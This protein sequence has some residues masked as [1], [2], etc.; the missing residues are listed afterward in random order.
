MK[1]FRAMACTFLGL[2]VQGLG[3]RPTDGF[4]AEGLGFRV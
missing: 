4:R 3:F 2:R 1:L